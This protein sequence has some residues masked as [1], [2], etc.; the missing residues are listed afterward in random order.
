MCVCVVSYG[1]AV[2]SGLFVPC[3]LCGCAYGRLLGEFMR[4]TFPDAGVI[5][6]TYALI[7]GAWRSGWTAGA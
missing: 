1:T 2:P 5:P 4:D 7:G 6:G 3:I